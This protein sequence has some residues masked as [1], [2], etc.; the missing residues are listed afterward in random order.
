[1]SKNNTPI[2]ET[3]NFEY[4]GTTEQF[5]TFLKS[6]IK[7]YISENNMLPD[8]KEYTIPDIQKTA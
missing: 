5:N 8:V 2:I 3:V 7:D 6:I 4:V 1:M